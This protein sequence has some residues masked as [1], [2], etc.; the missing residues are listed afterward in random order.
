MLKRYRIRDYDFKLVIMLIAISVIGILAIGSAQKSVQDKQ[1]MGLVLGVFLM[2]VISLFDY[3]ALL[4]LYWI[5]YIMNVVLLLLVEVMGY[6]AGGAQRWFTILGIRFQ[7]SELAKILL[8][9]FYAQF[10]MKQGERLNSFRGLVKTVALLFPPLLLIYKQ[11]D[12]S[13]SIMVVIIFCIVLF[14]GGLDYRI[15]AGVLAVVVPSIVIFLMIVLQPDQKLIKEYQQTR[16]LAWLHP[17]EYVNAEG[18]QQANS[19]M[20]IGSGQLWGKGLNNNII[21]SVKNGNFISEP[22]TDFIF[23]IIGEELGF[24]GS[25]TVI[26]LLFL[27]ALECVMIARKS[28]DTAGMIICSGMGSIIGFQSYMNIAVATGLMP[29][30]GIPL[31]FVSAGLTSLVS[32]FIGMGFVLNVRLQGKNTSIKVRDLQ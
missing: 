27:I 8:I 17:A 15:I 13:T 22:Q 23:A 18:Y 1:I 30:T 3:S 19:I 5:F 25:C 29:N 32:L 20:A 31:P 10:I 7:P 24:I 6:K 4:N 16:I 11:P 28:K 14:V 9:L 26:V 21:G 2:I 12:L